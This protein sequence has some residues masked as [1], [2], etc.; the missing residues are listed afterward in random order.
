[1]RRIIMPVKHNKNV[2]EKTTVVHK[3]WY[4]KFQRISRTIGYIANTWNK[5]KQMREVLVDRTPRDKCNV[6][7]GAWKS[8]PLLSLGL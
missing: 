1:M 8:D 5:M 2:S 6:L 7:P 4:L 3:D